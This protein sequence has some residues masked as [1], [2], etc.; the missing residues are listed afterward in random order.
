VAITTPRRSV[1]QKDQ[2]LVSWLIYCLPFN[3]TGNVPN[4]SRPGIAEE[5]GHQTEEKGSLS[6]KLRH[7]H[8]T[9]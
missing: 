6:L 1:S 8:M 9:A 3:G 2:K 5:F 7:R 4:Y